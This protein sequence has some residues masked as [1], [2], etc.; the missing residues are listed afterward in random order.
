MHP[1]L[2]VWF[3]GTSTQLKSYGAKT[4]KM[5]LANLVCYKHKPTPGVKT[6]SHAGAM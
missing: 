3:D 2:L 6:I 4:G 5:I 1:C